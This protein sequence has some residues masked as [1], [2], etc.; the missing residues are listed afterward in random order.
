MPPSIEK[1][2]RS[3]KTADLWAPEWA[4]ENE[5]D[6]WDRVSPGQRRR[7]DRLE[8]NPRLIAWSLLMDVNPG[9]AHALVPDSEIDPVFAELLDIAGPAASCH[10]DRPINAPSAMPGMYSNQLIS[11]DQ[12]NR[13]DP[14]PALRSAHVPALVL[15]GSCDY[16]RWEIAREYRDTLPDATLLAVPD[17]GHVIDADQPEL[18]IATVAGFLTGEPL[19]LPAY[20]GQEEP[21]ATV[22]R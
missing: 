12:A 7:I 4:D 19:P 2:Q 11:A 18:Y 5:G 15:R 13:P 1:Q 3:I 14:R 21:V 22:P 6:I 9:A 16:K 10:P 17:A 8:A 20:T